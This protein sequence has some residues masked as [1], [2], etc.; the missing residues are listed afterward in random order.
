[1]YDHDG[2][3]ILIEFAYIVRKPEHANADGDEGEAN[4]EESGQDGACGQ[5]WLP[6]W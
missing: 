5:D 1:M 2:N 4:D 3:R 6:S